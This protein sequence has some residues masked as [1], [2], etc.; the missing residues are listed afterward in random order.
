[1]LS[2]GDQVVGPVGN[3]LIGVQVMFKVVERLRSNGGVGIGGLQFVNIGL[4]V[5]GVSAGARAMS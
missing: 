5:L 2:G 1:M 4:I 3:L